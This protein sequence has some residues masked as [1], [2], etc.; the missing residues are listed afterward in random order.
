VLAALIFT[1][2]Y[3]VI[4]V[5]RLP[6]L[7]LDR[8]G[9]A[10]V[11]ASLM[12]A[13]GALSLEE[14]YGALDID[15]LV[16]L[17]GMMIVVANLRFAGFFHLANRWIARHAH[18]PL[19]LLAGIALVAGGLSAFL[20]NDTVCLML[21]P[22]IAELVLAL[23]RNPVPYL[24]ALA[25]ASNIGSTATITGNPQHIMI[26]SFSRVPYGDFAAALAPVAAAGLAVALVLIAVAWRG[27]FFTRAR[28]ASA[29][30]R[31]RWNPALLAK[32]LA[33]GLG[34]VVFFFL[35]QPPAKVAIVAGSLLLLTRRIKP[36]RVYRKIDWSLLLL[37]AGLFIV[38]A[39]MEKAVLGPTALGAAAHLNLGSPPVLAAVAAVLS[40]LVSNVPAVLVLKPFVQSL[41]EPRTAWLTLAMAATL[42]GN[43]TI[44]GSIANLIVVQRA[45][46]HGIEIGFWT[47]FK[48]GAPVTVITIVIGVLLLG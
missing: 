12:V 20:V 32:S 9:A 16:L 45:R 43:F 7:R 40:N 8:A 21:T 31:L 6:G 29:V 1:A 19:A 11:G 26:G 38:V 2:T 48:V 46:R 15:T 25:M 18:H 22:L 5:G 34:M 24:L 35:G 28:F 23:K 44:P 42:A 4:A 17:L 27:E 14:A 13:S 3:L 10:L 36:E 37:F 33:A 39:G 47:Y 30:P 41:A